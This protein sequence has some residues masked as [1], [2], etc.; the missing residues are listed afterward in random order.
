MS[1]NLGDDKRK[2][3]DVNE[4]GKD[5]FSKTLD[6][7]RSVVHIRKAVFVQATFR[8]CPAK[9]G[10]PHSCAAYRLVGSAHVIF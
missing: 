3:Q 8:K 4:I 2:M 7:E 5:F 1:S 6:K 9:S 10:P